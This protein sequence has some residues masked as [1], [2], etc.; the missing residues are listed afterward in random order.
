L[1]GAR[2]TGANEATPSIVRYKVMMRSDTSLL[3]GWM[4]VKPVATANR[5]S[6]C[7]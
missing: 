6:Y 4:H 3:F 2:T 5:T 7:S 1:V